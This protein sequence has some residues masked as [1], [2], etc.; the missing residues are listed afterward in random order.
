MENTDSA[1]QN[2]ITMVISIL[3]KKSLK[4]FNSKASGS[5][6]RVIEALD[7]QLITPEI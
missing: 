3:L 4:T 7:G 2:D 5:K 6:V 1:N